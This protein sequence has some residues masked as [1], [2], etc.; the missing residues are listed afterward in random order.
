MSEETQAITIE[1]YKEYIQLKD[2]LANTEKV[3]EEYNKNVDYYQ[4]ELA[5]SWLTIRETAREYFKN[6]EDK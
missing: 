3:I 2:Q 4:S 6:K 1:E 5:G